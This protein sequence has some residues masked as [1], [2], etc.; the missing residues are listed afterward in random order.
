MTEHDDVAEAT[1]ER[2][3]ELQLE[4]G[5][6]T[7]E[8]N[9]V[10]GEEPTVATSRFLAMA[11][12]TVDQAVAAARR[13]ADEIVEEIC[14]Q[15]ELRRDEAT[16]VAAEAE[17]LAVAKRAEADDAQSVIDAA[18][19]EAKSIQLSAEIEAERWAEGER[20]K[21]AE[22]V[23]AELAKVDVVREELMEE[24]VSLEGYHQVLKGR[25]QDLA[26]T[27]V[28]F[29][30]NQPS[31]GAVAT[32]ESLLPGSTD[33]PVAVADRP[34]VAAEQILDV[35]ESSIDEIPDGPPAPTVAPEAPAPVAEA[36]V[37]P[38]DPLAA[39]HEVA[40]PAPVAESVAPEPEAF[41][42]PAP[43]VA[44]EPVAPAYVAPA[45]TI[46]EP[47]TLSA[48]PIPVAA[49]VASAPEMSV[50]APVDDVAETEQFETDDSG[51][52]RSIKGLFSR[53]TAEEAEATEPVA[54]PAAPLAEAAAPV[55]PPVAAP[56]A[57]SFTSGLA[58]ALEGSAADRAHAEEGT[59]DF[60]G[61]AKQ[62]DPVE[63]AP[64]PT[65]FGMLGS[66]L[67]QDAAA[68]DP[69]AGP[70]VVEAAPVE[71][72]PVAAAPAAI[73]DD[74]DD[75]AFLQFI[76]GDDEPDPSRDWLLRPEEG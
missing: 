20:A 34:E 43:P 6:L 30:S 45:A 62:A 35:P 70:P 50:A 33:E 24:Q 19:S 10:R 48:D 27:M 17:A 3:R 55:A 52:K 60:G 4:V 57:D 5:R 59:T 66:R 7:A 38:V 11:A 13:E 53:A 39:Q 29:M 71:P 1:T 25:V 75:R 56:V 76:G 8:L 74:S 28:S 9:M 69:N 46:V 21:V 14:A 51:E 32:M 58:A 16:R 15:A 12:A 63:D 44:P 47:S 65:L 36:E 73:G 61:I 42:A 37:A 72:A 40:E 2:E 41:V 68:E 26:E 23:A 67:R 31:V 54:A 49:P 18:H 22:Q 64:K